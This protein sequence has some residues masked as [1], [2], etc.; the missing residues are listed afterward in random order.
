MS[1]GTVNAPLRFGQ[2]REDAPVEYRVPDEDFYV[3]E[4]IGN[5]D[6]VQSQYQDKATGE[7]PM[8]ANLKF[9]VV[10]DLQG[11]LEFQDCEVG[12]FVGL[13][14]NPNDKGSILHVL[15]ALDPTADVEPGASLAPFI[16]K[17]MIAEITHTTK[18]RKNKPGETATFANI[19]GFKPAKKQKKAAAAVPAP[20]PNPLLDDDD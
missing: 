12:K 6:P 2:Y 20:E 17:Q 19:A 15:N 3:V 8:R 4:L 9:R 1:T 16:G 10:A 7:F 5:D 13:D 18:P 11:D 14:I